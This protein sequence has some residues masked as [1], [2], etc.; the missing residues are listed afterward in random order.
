MRIQS[1]GVTG[2]RQRSGARA[3]ATLG[4]PDDEPGLRASQAPPLPRSPPRRDRRPVARRRHGA[5]RERRQRLGAHRARL[6]RRLDR[7][8]LPAHVPTAVAGRAAPLRPAPPSATPTCA[9]APPR[10]RPRS[11]SASPR[12]GG[13][14]RRAAAGGAAH[15][16][17]RPLP[18]R[19]ALPVR[20]ERVE[21]TPEPRLPR[22]RAR[23]AAD[24]HEQAARA[25]HAALARG[26][27]A[28]D[29]TRPT[30]RGSPLGTLAG[31]IAGQL[32]PEETAGEREALYARG[33]PRDQ[34]VGQTGL[35]HVFE[36]QS[37]G[38]A[39]RRCCAPARGCS[40]ARGRAR[41]RRCAPRSTSACRRPR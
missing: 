24:A 32:S 5:R 37:A 35:E 3:R 7:P 18:R 34:P 21:W 25:R 28:G 19:R 14:R 31:S 27:G 9:P 6:R 1:S 26:Q 2:A 41:R 12:R 33:F 29:R 8:G 4:A 23:R 20:D 40:P 39:R 11:R 15:A 17:V 30:S 16:R 13:R 10:R 36:Q 22:P 38:R